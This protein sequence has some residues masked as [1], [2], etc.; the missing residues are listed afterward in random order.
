MQASYQVV[1]DPDLGLDYSRVVHGDQRFEHV[2]P[3]YA[4][5]ELTVVVT[6]EKIRSIAGTDII[7]TRA[8]ISG[9]SGELVC[10]AVSTLAARAPEAAS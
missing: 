1:L 4:G 9:A 3:I 7:T 5:D 8:D 10:S 2:R 6:V